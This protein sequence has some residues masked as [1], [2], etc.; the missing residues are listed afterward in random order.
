MDRTIVSVDA[1]CA[2]RYGPNW[3]RT[4]KSRKAKRDTVTR[5]C[6]DGVLDARKAGRSWLIEL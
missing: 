5:M 6:R 4:Q 2:I 3:D 1:F